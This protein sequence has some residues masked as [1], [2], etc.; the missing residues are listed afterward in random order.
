MF[1]YELGVIILML[2]LNAIFTA[3]EMGLA[4]ISRS[5]IAILVNEHKKGATDA[6]FMKDRMEASLAVIQ[7][8]VTLFT[9]I[10]AATG[11]VGAQ[12][13]FAPYLAQHWHISMTL[14][15]VIAVT[16]VIIP[17]TLVTIVFVELVPKMFAL[18]NKEW[19]VLR[20]S[21][22]IRI[23]AKIID[24]FVSVIEFVVKKIV[25][26]IARMQPETRDAQAPWLHEL[27][28][29][30]SLARTSKLMGER[31]EKIV[32]AAAHLSSHLVRDIML[33]AQDISMIYVGS[34][35]SHALVKA[36]LDM[37]TRFPICMVENDPQTIERYLN[38]KDI[39]S[40]LRVNPSDPTIKG[41]SRPI[42]RVKEDMPL[43]KL[44]EMMIQEK[45]H[46]VIV[47]S[48]ENIVLGM[49]TLEDIIE[50]LVGEIED[51]FDRLPTHIHPAG[52]GW[53][54]G[55]G[56]LMTTV[57]SNLGL[58][59]SEKFTGRVPTLAE[60]CNQ[61]F[62]SPL[63]GGETIESDNLRVVPRKFRRKKLQEA[64][65]SLVSSNS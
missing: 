9:T 58:D 43:S 29:A 35:L 23:L 50:E 15:K 11:G 32:L 4:T 31:E 22:V 10:A 37:H 61:T 19:I 18:S 5:R 48:H 16:F 36:H 38:F 45:T 8:G 27:R 41:I 52:V 21:P 17:L 7:L 6:A 25:A 28:A 56:V 14:A 54:M 57:A 49:I 20:L 60:W 34:T 13:A 46:I 30:V 1:N 47:V 2:I 53:I 42:T 26:A 51:E 55:G 33:P 12:D 3:Y 24:P 65:V 63:K 39:V 59:W 64:I 44:L 40:A 62:G